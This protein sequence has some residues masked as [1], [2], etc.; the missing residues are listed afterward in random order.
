MWA[1]GWVFSWGADLT[2]EGGAICFPACLVVLV[3]E[4]PGVTRTLKLLSNSTK[5]MEQAPL[6]RGKPL[7]AKIP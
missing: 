7:E 4:T 5:Y 3:L 2:K 1:G 6:Q